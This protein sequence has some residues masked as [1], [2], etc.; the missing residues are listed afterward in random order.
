MT[1]ETRSTVKQVAV[2]AALAVSLGGNAYL[3]NEVR[4]LQSDMGGYRQ[5]TAALI[6]GAQERSAAAAGETARTIQTL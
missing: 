1:H 2:A 4:D 3:F 5:E 6:Q